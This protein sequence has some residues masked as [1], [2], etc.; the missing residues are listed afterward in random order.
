MRNIVS[1]GGGTGLSI[2]IAGL[3]SKFNVS[4]I[5]TVGDNGGGSGILR[6]D[7]NMLPP[8][9]VRNCLLALSDAPETL[10]TLLAFRFKKGQLQGQSLGNLMIAGMTEEF[11][12]F[13][14]AIYFLGKVLNIKGKVIPVSLDSMDL[15]A[16]LSNGDIIY[17]ESEIAIFSL[18]RK[19]RITELYLNNRCQLSSEAKEAIKKSEL[20]TLGPGSLYTSVISNLLVDGIVE[21]L[22]DK[23]IVYVSNI[24]TQPEETYNYKLKDHVDEI[25][26][27]L[28][29][30]ID[31]VLVNTTVPD[32]A[33]LEKYYAEGSVPIYPSKDEY[34]YFGDKII[35]GDFLDVK[36]G[37]IRTDAVK[38]TECLEQL[39]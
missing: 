32:D 19:A 8:G 22:A 11:N 34:E 6:A 4:A 33:V 39:C 25:E 27:Y 15:V 18:K 37:Y 17:G 2:L 1:I 3:K 35:T 23:K 26:K 21:L 7:L 10:N 29:R 12:S 9:D 36:E 5:V 16:K 13:E 14:K 30:P 24:M 31:Y 20:I 28:K 38:V